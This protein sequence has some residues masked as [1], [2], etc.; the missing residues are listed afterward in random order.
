MNRIRNEFLLCFFLGFFGAHRFYRKQTG[1]GFLYLFTFGLFGI[2][3][4]VDTIK[5]LVALIKATSIQTKP[6]N[7]VYPTPAHSSTSYEHMEFKLAGVTYKNDDG[8][9]RQTLLR[10]FRFN[11]P[12]FND[13]KEMNLREYDY[14]GDPALAVEANGLMLGNVPA[15]QVQEIIDNWHRLDGITAVN[16][17]GGSEGKSFGARVTLRFRK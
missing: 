9:N 2:G 5:L 6:I 8:S 14:L 1:L 4:L 7:P 3:W 11:D 15:E 10:R 16:V 13:M 17:Y 12:P